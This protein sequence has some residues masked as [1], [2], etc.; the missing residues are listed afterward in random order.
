MTEHI[1]RTTTELHPDIRNWKLPETVRRKQLAEGKQDDDTDSDDSDS[2]SKKGKRIPRDELLKPFDQYRADVDS[3]TTYAAFAAQYYHDVTPP[4]RK[5]SRKK[6]NCIILSR[7][8][9]S[10]H[11]MY[12]PN[13]FSMWS[14]TCL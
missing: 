14:N 12:G 6:R 2:E 8:V 4:I 7:E 11:G 10:R 5:D 9:Q 1:K 3:D 13:S